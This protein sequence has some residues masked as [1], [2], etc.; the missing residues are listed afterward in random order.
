MEEEE[1]W[2]IEE[3]YGEK[4]EKMKVIFEW[5]KGENDIFSAIFSHE[6]NRISEYKVGTKVKI[7]D[8]G[9]RPSRVFKSQ[10]ILQ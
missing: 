1:W 9:M 8:R 2:K 6:I 3:F 4:G 10:H 7:L 5:E